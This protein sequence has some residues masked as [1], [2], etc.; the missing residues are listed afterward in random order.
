MFKKRTTQKTFKTGS[1][2]KLLKERRQRP[3]GSSTSKK[4]YTRKR[5]NHIFY[6]FTKDI[7][8]TGSQASTTGVTHVYSEKRNENTKAER[9]TLTL[10][11]RRTTQSSHNNGTKERPLRTTKKYT[12]ELPLKTLIPILNKNV[13]IL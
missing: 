6:R 12:A 13:Q 9:D 5:L 2:V 4:K 10:I 1:E 7:S 11:K 8:T 3:K